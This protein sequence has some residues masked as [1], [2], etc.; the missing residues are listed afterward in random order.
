MATILR[1]DFPD[2]IGV[3]ALPA[4]HHIIYQSYG[5][6]PDV[7]PQIMRMEKS[8]KAIEQTTTLGSFTV[9]PAMIE[10]ED[11]TYESVPQGYDKTYVHV[12]Y[13]KGFKL[14]DAMLRHGKFLPIRR[15]SENLGR[16]IAE[17][18]Q[19][20]AAGNF[21]TAFD[22]AAAN[23]NGEALCAVD[24]A[25][26]NGGTSANRPAVDADLSVTSLRAMHE[27]MM[28]VRDAG[29]LR[30]NITPTKILV[31][32]HEYWTALELM[33][34]AKDP[35]SNWNTYNALQAIPLEIVVGR[36]L[37]DEDAWFLMGDMSQSE[38]Y[39]FEELPLTIKAGEDFDGDATKV[40]ACS[41]FSTGWSEWRNY[42]GSSG[43]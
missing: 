40:K 8:D 4:I 14:T 36:Y 16:S 15:L 29:Y 6:V 34:S 35:E 28:D 38:M 30:A 24:H 23:P 9:A 3:D 12:K 7:I 39:F 41:W 5:A 43:A 1:T 33:K 26:E 18:R 27:L 31:A 10:G 13:G 25:L 20:A 32:P 37:T 17:A 22:A 11:Y 42:A 2:L 19:I 21:N